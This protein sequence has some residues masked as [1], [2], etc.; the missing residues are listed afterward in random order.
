MRL[1]RRR[2]R[3]HHPLFWTLLGAGAVVG[4]YFFGGTIPAIS[5]FIR[6]RRM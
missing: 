6:M 2:K 1:I 3:N 4:L 5:R